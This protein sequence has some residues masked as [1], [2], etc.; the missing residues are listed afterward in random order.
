MLEKYIDN[1]IRKKHLLEGMSNVLKRKKTNTK[2][3]EK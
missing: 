3:Y 2:N 1:E